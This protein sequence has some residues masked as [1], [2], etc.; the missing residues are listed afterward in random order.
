MLHG[1]GTAKFESIDMADHYCTAAD[2][3]NRIT[4]NG[5]NHFFNRDNDSSVSSSEIAAYINTSIERVDSE[6][7]VAIQDKYDTAAARGNVWL[8]FIAIDLAVVAA[9]TIGGREVNT[10][11]IEFSDQA[12]KQLELVRTGELTIPGLTPLQLPLE[13]TA[14]V[15]GFTIADLTC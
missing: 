4:P 11:L 15:R 5:M 6:I 9:G 3:T 14:E 2:I 13:A 1:R 7:D 8:K 10:Q 12:R